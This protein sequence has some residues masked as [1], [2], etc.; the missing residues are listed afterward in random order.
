LL[1]F[2]CASQSQDRTAKPR[3]I[4][5]VE[6]CHWRV[7]RLWTRMSIRGFRW[8]MMS[9][10]CR[11]GITVPK[12]AARYGDCSLR[13]ERHRCVR[14]PNASSIRLYRNSHI[15]RPGL[16]HALIRQPV[17]RCPVVALRQCLKEFTLRGSQTLNNNV[18]AT[19]ERSVSASTSP[20]AWSSWRAY[21]LQD[22][23]PPS[24]DRLP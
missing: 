18:C 15:T 20:P 12:M 2:P 22:P 17:R 8:L 5:L 24:V 1:A 10:M 16:R 6:H 19:R 21:H 3:I 14:L 23:S 4:L 9:A 13:G 11:V 7:C